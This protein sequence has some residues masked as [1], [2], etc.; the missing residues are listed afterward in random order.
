MNLTLR[1]ELT[2]QLSKALLSLGLP[3]KAAEISP[4]KATN[5]GDYQSNTAIVLAKSL[6]EDPKTV[7][8]QILSHLDVSGCS[9]HPEIAGAGF[10]NFR[11]LNSHLIQR[12]TRLS[13]DTRLGVPYACSSRRI[14]I[15][16]SSPN[17]AKPMHVGHIRATVLGDALA[18]IARFLG[19]EVITDNHVGDWG[20]HFGKVIY[21]WKL[22]L[23]SDHLAHDPIS[24]LVRLYRKVNHLETEDVR[25]AK[26]VRRE[27]VLL[28]RKDTESLSIWNR[29]VEFSRK[30]FE[31]IYKILDI[32][33]DHQLGE[34]FYRNELA[35]L[36]Q[37]LL[38]T[39]I[40]QKSQGAICIFFPDIPELIDKPC[41]VRKS[42]GGFLYATID[43]AAL[44]YRA[45]T[46]NPDAIWYVAGT[47]Q[48]LHFKQVFDIARR[49]DIPAKLS[50]IAFG[51]ILGKNRKMMKTRAGDNIPLS[52]LLQE[53]ITRAEQIIGKK[54]PLLSIE[55]KKV[56]ARI[57]G[58]GA[59]KYAEL[60]QN[61]LSDYVFSWEKM[62]AFQGN[63]APYLQNA[64]V[65][66]R[67]IFGKLKATL[68]KAA[69]FYL[70]V[71]EERALA[72]K[73][74]QFGETLPR[75]LEDFRPNLLANYLFELANAFHG[76]YETCPVLSAEE[77]LRSSRLMFCQL[78]KQILGKGLSLLGIKTPKKM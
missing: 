23:N 56:A 44:E 1:K 45:K 3:E 8:E 59:I 35:P 50:H 2:A 47:P 40:A 73:L 18:R 42:D 13:H 66:I 21:G 9:A 31:D 69:T 33:F 78:S 39:G 6:R 62:L 36:V 74:L 58:I 15:D 34:S 30:A 4:A 75:V 5:F 11:I 43:L 24:E 70:H 68:P 48:S 49:L 12:L 57:I 46:W 20:A 77:S 64:Y 52:L 22:F 65:R 10:L 61:R 72:L 19:H 67:S 60:S 7:A 55:E 29:I 37:R 32:H 76:F 14:V 51:S 71:P 27:L 54:N 25:I 38:D 26:K 53:A 28:Q 17:M 63:T 16:F 41:L